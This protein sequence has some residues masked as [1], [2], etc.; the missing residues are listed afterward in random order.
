MRALP[1][2]AL[3]V[4]ICVV[5]VASAAGTNG[6]RSCADERER[7]KVE[8]VYINGVIHTLEAAKPVVEAISTA[9]G[10]ILE[11]GSSAEILARVAPG[12]RIVDLRGRTVIPALT[13]AHAH[14]MG[15]AMNSTK[16]DLTVTSSLDGILEMVSGKLVGAEPGSWV[17]GRGW[18]Q[19][20]W[21]GARYPERAALDRIAPDNPVYL[22]RVCGHAAYVNSA[23]LRLAGITRDTADPPGG[24]ILKEAGGEPSGILLDDAMQLVDG[25]I[26]SR[27]RAE[28]KGLLAAAARSCLA[29]GL[30]GVHEMGMTAE[31][32]SIY[33][34]IYAAGD[35][36]FR[37]TGYLLPDDPGNA[38]FL[39]AGPLEGDGDGLF[40][41]VGVK[42]FADGSLGARSAALLEDYSDEPLNRGILMKSPEALCGEIRPWRERGFQIAVHAIG[43]AAVREVL[44][45]YERLGAEGLSL[46]ARNR[47]E[48]AQVIS[49]ADMSRFAALGAIASMQFKHCTSDMP[50]AEARLGRDRIA[51]AYAWRSLVDAG[52]HVPGG[53]DFPV[54]PISPFLGI[55]AAVTRQ[56]AAGSPEGG[57][58]GEQRIT[59]EE[60]VRAFTAE[61]AYAGRAERVAGSL[62]PGKLADFVV[63]SEDIFSMQP[64]EISRTRVLATVLGGEIVY[65]SK[66]F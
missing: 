14:F 7:S 30:V 41:I 29:A 21:P 8:I 62:S 13:D 35:L 27:T 63:I 45:V 25:A 37:I 52:V 64:G 55:H 4:G 11:T 56:D 33:R 18:D 32:V 28:K 16:L 51:G 1:A 22:V 53:S 66:D 36:P 43:D 54:E 61:A 2:R 60:A 6:G 39:D 48:H 19:N 65:S 9:G 5:C 44:D 24:R 47:V 42:F 12:T 57:W 38:S 15:Y 31:A 50:W 46:D 23:A 58:Q 40:R 34:E 49:P 10:R 17:L 3:C 26:P 20:D 59:V